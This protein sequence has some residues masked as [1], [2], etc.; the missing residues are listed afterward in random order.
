MRKNILTLVVALLFAASVCAQQNRSFAEHIRTV[1]TIVNDDRTLPAVIALDSDDKVTISFDDITHEYVRYVYKLEHC[2]RN[3]NTSDALFESDYM[4]GTN[5]EDP[6]D[7]YEQSMNTTQLYTHYTLDFPNSYV[8]PLLSGN[9]RVSIYESGATESPVAVACFSVVDKKMGIGAM[10]TTNTDIDN[11]ESHQ[12]LDLS[13]SFWQV[14]VRNPDREICVKV[15]QNKRSDNAITA[16]AATY[17]DGDGMKWEHCRELIFDAGNE[18]KKFEIL[19][20]HQATMGVDR[21]RWYEPYYHAFLYTEKPRK[22]YINSQEQN[23]SYVIRNEDDS[24]ND[25][26]SEYVI[27]H[28]SLDTEEISGGNFYVCGQWSGYNF[29]PE[30]KMRYDATE[31]MYT[32][33]ILMKQGYYNYLCL[34]VP[35]GSAEGSPLEAEGSFFQTENEYTVLVYAHLQGERYDRLLG[36]RDFRFIPNK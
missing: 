12:Q 14:E 1:E 9:Y 8:R 30:Y 24:D 5:F 36:Y 29:T 27:V 10:V 31:G 34:F 26:Q 16:P 22:N 15:L 35:D 17:Q 19:N 23:G 2:D 21:M 32:A 18:Y 20:V 3:W 25:T 13:V 6:I 33:E 28:F 7:N 11:N 4:T